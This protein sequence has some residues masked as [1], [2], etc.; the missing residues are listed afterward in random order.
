MA[1]LALHLPTLTQPGEFIPGLPVECAA[2]CGVVLDLEDDNPAD[3]DGDYYCGQCIGP[4]RADA[5]RKAIAEDIPA[6]IGA[7][8]DHIES[9][10]KE[11]HDPIDEDDGPWQMLDDARMRTQNSYSRGVD[12]GWRDGMMIDHSEY[13]SLVRNLTIVRDDMVSSLLVKLR[14]IN[15]PNMHNYSPWAWEM[16]DQTIRI[17]RLSRQIEALTLYEKRT[18]DGARK[19]K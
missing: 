5:Y 9:K 8:I 11:Y 7:A 15:N 13:Y 6:L 4:A 3:C 19:V 1:Y 16:C 10:D 14:L 12:T 17:T 2:K 18:Q